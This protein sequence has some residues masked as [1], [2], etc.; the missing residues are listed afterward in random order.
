[1]EIDREKKL[2]LLKRMLLI[3]AFE[4]KA[5]ELFQQKLIPGFVHLSIG[6]EASTTGS[7]M[8]LRPDDY[9]IS[10]HRGHA[11]ILAK[12][13]DPRF[14]FAELFGKANRILQGQRRLHAHS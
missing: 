13:A 3:R 1:M 12:G 4:E 2:S 10:T 7:C 14:M 9:I 6:Q 8:A 11:H 5:E